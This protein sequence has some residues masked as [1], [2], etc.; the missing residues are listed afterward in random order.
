MEG[1]GAILA[2]HLEALEKEILNKEGP[3][4]ETKYPQ[5]SKEE[6]EK[7]SFDKGKINYQRQWFLG[8]QKKLMQWDSEIQKAAK[9]LEKEGT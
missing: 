8:F 1:D 2:P 6:A 9:E 4:S 7:L 3:I 5:I